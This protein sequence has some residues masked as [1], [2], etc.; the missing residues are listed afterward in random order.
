MPLAPAT[1]SDQGDEQ[2][3]RHMSVWLRSSCLRLGMNTA[4]VDM[5]ARLHVQSELAMIVYLVAEATILCMY[6]YMLYGAGGSG[7][8]V[9]Y[10]RVPMAVSLG[11]HALLFCYCCRSDTSRDRKSAV[12]KAVLLICV[13]SFDFFVM[14]AYLCPI[15]LVP[16]GSSLRFTFVLAVLA[17]CLHLQLVLI[18]PHMPSKPI[19]SVL[20]LCISALVI[21]LR[22][23]NAVTD[24][25]VLQVLA[26]L[27]RSRSPLFICAVICIT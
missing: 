11:S 19:R 10:F 24:L 27:V 17:L 14:L 13:L 8:L 7:A 21:T 2:H 23:V 1:D 16:F 25:S 26:A 22:S 6:V 20:S 9:Y 15:D 3:E 12:C 4:A 18:P 5:W